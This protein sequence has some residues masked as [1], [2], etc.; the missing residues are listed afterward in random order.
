MNLAKLEVRHEK[1]LKDIE[2]MSLKKQEVEVNLL[3]HLDE[4]T[5]LQKELVSAPFSTVK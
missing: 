4:K 2:Y 3:R 5:K 1:Y